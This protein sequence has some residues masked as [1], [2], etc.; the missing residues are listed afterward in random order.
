[1]KSVVVLDFGSQYSQ[2]IVRRFREMGYYSTLLNHDCSKEEMESQDPGMFVLSGG[3]SSVYEKD[4]PKIPN[5]IFNFSVPILGICYGLQIIID[6][7]GGV[8][9]KSKKREFGHSILKIDADDPIFK[10]IPNRIRVW[11]SHSDRVEKLPYGFRSIAR[12]ENSPFAVVRDESGKIYGVQFHPEVAHTEHGTK[13]LENFARNVA[14]LEKNWSMENYV[15]KTIEELKNRI[16]N[17]RVITAVSGGVD[18]TVV[19]VLLNRAIGDRVIPVFID[20]GFMRKGEKEEI[21]RSFKELGIKV[22]CL[23]AS[24]RFLKALENV[25]DPEEKRRRIGHTFIT[26]FKEFADGL[27]KK[28]GRIRYLAQG[29]LYPDVVESRAPERKDASKIKTHHNVGGL[30]DDLPFELI[31]PLRYLFKDEVRKIGKIL[32]IPDEVLNRHPF[33][34][35]GYAIR[36]IGKITEE[37][38]RILRDADEI[39][40]EELRKYGLYEKLWQAFMVL[41]PVKSVGV[42]GDRRTYE[43]VL[44]LR[45][46][47]S[48]DGMTADWSRLPYDFLNK[49][50]TRIVNEVNGV[51]RVVYDITSKPPATIEWE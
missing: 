35:P 47:E 28:V 45:A 33:P 2:L 49:V 31:E 26:V 46:V 41:L 6:K 12:T 38:I 27:Q 24:R 17:D 30:P 14:K 20:T 5:F 50:S 37:R 36:I 39:L 9:G 15:E 29:T 42:M 10:G 1:M 13:I 43:N 16:K 19:T 18:S 22:E 3:P 34:G 25:E 44:V 21:E 23:T 51:N 8:V 32:G 48:V 7:F 4:A 11:M 40:F